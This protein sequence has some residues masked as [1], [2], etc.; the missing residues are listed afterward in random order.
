VN[1]SYTLKNFRIRF[2]SSKEMECLD[3]NPKL[4]ETYASSL[5]KNNPPAR[6]R[7]ADGI[8]GV[9]DAASFFKGVVADFLCYVELC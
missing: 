8:Q 7:R 3:S 1:K 2:V 5:I 6:N 4:V 9:E